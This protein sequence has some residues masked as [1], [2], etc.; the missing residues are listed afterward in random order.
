MTTS[1]ERTRAVVDTRQLLQTLAAGEEIAMANLVSAVT[2]GLLLHYPLDV[3]LAKS[4]A[5]L[6]GIWGTPKS[7]RT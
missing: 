3:D 4:A 5:A 6:P 1:D 7:K 2:I